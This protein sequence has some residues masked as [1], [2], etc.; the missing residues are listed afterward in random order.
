MLLPVQSA[1]V[2]SA[3]PDENFHQDGYLYT[4]I[5]PHG[6]KHHTLLQFNFSG[7]PENTTVKAA[8]LRLYSGHSWEEGHPGLPF[9]LA[10]AWDEKTVTWENQ[11]QCADCTPGKTGAISH[12]WYYWDIS[13]LVH[14]WRENDENNHGLILQN[15]G[16]EGN[17]RRFHPNAGGDSYRPALILECD[18]A[19][20]V[21]LDNRTTVNRTETHSVGD[22]PSFSQWQNTSKYDTYTFFARNTGANPARAH[23]QISPEKC[24]IFNEAAVYDLLPGGTQ[25]IVPQRYAFHTRL[26]LVTVSPDTRTRVKIWFQAHV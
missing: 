19:E 24:A 18:E 15:N 26:A 5:D 14:H 25:A 2:C 22:T 23:V 12:G 21:L 13:N 11:P 1:Y 16:E 10:S 9:L 6:Y 7:L 17:I 4:G 3:R 20:P 8:L